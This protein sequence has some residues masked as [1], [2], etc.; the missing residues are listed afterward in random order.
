MVEALFPETD[1][2]ARIKG[3]LE[4]SYSLFAATLYEEI[5]PDQPLDPEVF[6]FD[7]NDQA[8]PHYPL[9]IKWNNRFHEFSPL[10]LPDGILTDADIAATFGDFL[11]GARRLIAGSVS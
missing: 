1:Q 6:N 10:T 4:H 5:A 7:L 8:A 2:A 3:F 9:R 11:D